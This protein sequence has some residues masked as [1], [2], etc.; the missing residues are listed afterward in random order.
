[1]G[2]NMVSKG[3]EKALK[4]ILERFPLA[5]IE[6]LSGN[7]CT[8]KKPSAMNWIEG[9]GKSIVAECLIPEATLKT[10]LKVTLDQLER[11]NV[12]KNLIGSSVAG[13]VGGFNA[14]VA[15]VV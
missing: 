14:H 10:I 1:M 8:D 13:S 11:L 6:S 4:F 12:Q 5:K 9:R 3:A 7:V 2:M 15:N